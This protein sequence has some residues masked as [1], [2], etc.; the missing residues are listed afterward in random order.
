MIVY[1][2][3]RGINCPII[4]R[5]NVYTACFI[6]SAVQSRV[7]ISLSTCLNKYISNDIVPASMQLLRAQNIHHVTC[8]HD[9]QHRNV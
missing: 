2:I 1:E 7:P 5:F 8:I 4:H 9:L 6:A 3:P